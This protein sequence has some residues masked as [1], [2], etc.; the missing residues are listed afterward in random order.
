[1]QITQSQLKDNFH[2][3]NDIGRFVWKVAKGWVK[4]GRIAGTVNGDN[5]YRY[6][7]LNGVHY[8]EHRMVWLYVH[9]RLP[10]GEIDHINGDKKDNRIVNLRQCTRSQNEINKGLSRVNTSGCKGVS[11]H[12]QS[13]KW[14]ARLKVNKK[15]VH[16]G[17]F[18]N[19]SDAERAYKLFLQNTHGD[20]LLAGSLQVPGGK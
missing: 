18:E 10:E 7:K 9:G 20:F 15:E 14:R 13:K 12:A 11:W 8:L 6:I 17:T 2:Y 16:L 19:K 3:R 1:M 5:G 4:P